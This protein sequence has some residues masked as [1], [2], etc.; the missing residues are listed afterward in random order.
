M[1]TQFDDK[2]KIFTQVVTK[3]PVSVVINTAHHLIHGSIHVRPGER[4]IDELN[5]SQTFLAVTDA[6]IT[7]LEGSPL[8][9]SAFLTLNTDQIIW[10][11]PSDEMQST[12]VEG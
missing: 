8:F 10:L 7:D 6:K 12:K 9:E 11:V 4:V 1:V 5:H 3:T 2:G